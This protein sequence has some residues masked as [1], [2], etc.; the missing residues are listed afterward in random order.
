MS[1]TTAQHRQT[2]QCMARAGT[3]PAD[4]FAHDCPGRSK[5][6]NHLSATLSSAYVPPGGRHGIQAAHTDSALVKH[7]E[8]DR[9]PARAPMALPRFSTVSP[10]QRASAA[11]GCGPRGQ[12]RMTHRLREFPPPAANRDRPVA[13]CR[14]RVRVAARRSSDRHLYILSFTLCVLQ[15][16]M[17]FCKIYNRTPISQKALWI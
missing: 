2:G 3:Q 9:P 7:A 1:R 4:L 15:K 11:E 13:Q 17:Y 12:S 5:P 16:N 14:H 6:L 10:E 8:T